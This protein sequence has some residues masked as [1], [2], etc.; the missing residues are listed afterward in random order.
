MASDL[1]HPL[2]TYTFISTVTAAV[3][4]IAKT[5]TVGLP[6]VRA[7]RQTTDTWLGVPAALR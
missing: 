7:S 3:V 5:A 6:E 2:C 4:R 1:G